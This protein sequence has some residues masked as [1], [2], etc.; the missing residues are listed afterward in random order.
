MKQGFF[1]SRENLRFKKFDVQKI[2]FSTLL[3]E[4]NAILITEAILALLIKI[5]EIF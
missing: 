3:L 4:Q 1:V 2:F 5:L